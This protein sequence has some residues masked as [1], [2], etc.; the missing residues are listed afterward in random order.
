MTQERFR[1]LSS[2]YYQARSVF[3]SVRVSRR[4]QRPGAF[5]RVSHFSGVGALTSSA[6]PSAGCDRER[7]VSVE[8]AR[9]PRAGPI[10][11]ETMKTEATKSLLAEMDRIH[12]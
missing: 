7:S 5:D 11:S 10:Y 12:P 1:G 9:H 4:G 8:Q 3:S 2:K 6:P